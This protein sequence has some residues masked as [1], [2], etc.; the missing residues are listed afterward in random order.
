MASTIR[1]G[2][3]VSTTAA[4][5]LALAGLT[6][7][8]AQAA[9]P[10][11]RTTLDRAPAWTTHAVKVG[12]TPAA[13]TQHLTAVLA[14]RD[15]AGAESLAAAVSDPSSAAYGHFVSA[16]QLARPLRAPQLGRRQV[17]AWLRASGFTVGAIPANH[18]TISFSG[19]TAQVE[20]AFATD[21]QT[22][23]GPGRRVSANARRGVGAPGPRRHRRSASAAWT[24][25]ARRTPD[26][27]GGPRRDAA[28]TRRPRRPRP[29][30]GRACR[31]APRPARSSGTPRPAPP[32]TARRPPP[33]VPQILGR[34]AHLRAVRLQAGAAAGRLRGARRRWPPGHDGRGATIAILD[35]YASPTILPD[36]QTYAAGTTPGIRCAATSSPSRCPPA[37]R[38]S[39]KCDAA[40]WY[41]EETLDVEAAHATA[42]AANILYVGGRSCQDADLNAAMN[43]VVDNAARPGHQQLLRQRRRAVV[44][45]RRRRGAPDVPAGRGRGHQRAVLLRRQRRRGRQHRHAAGRLRGVRPAGSPRSAARPRR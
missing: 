11:P 12:Q 37:T 41:G 16:A 4:M 20:K 13:Q 42:P 15:A 34:P 8:L 7:A 30:A 38:S 1:R 22:F 6:P 45:G 2:A 29:A 5:T 14:L 33:T 40:G 21:L 26:H 25:R 3:V 24:P 28:T 27:T 10:S 18:R 43:T 36:A 9:G 23:A 19:T 32:T 31:H 44:D 35:A 39:T 17:T